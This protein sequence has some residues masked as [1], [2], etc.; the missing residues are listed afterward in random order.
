METVL[1]YGLTVEIFFLNNIRPVS[2]VS[3]FNL[4]MHSHA[5]AVRN[6]G[7]LEL[8]GR[9]A[10]IVPGRIESVLARDALSA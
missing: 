6:A 1:S 3:P 8:R 2:N 9:H 4:A 5:G 10:G 7:E